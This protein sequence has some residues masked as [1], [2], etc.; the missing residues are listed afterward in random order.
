MLRVMLDTRVPLW[1]GRGYSSEP[2]WDSPGKLC[3]YDHWC[4]GWRTW[5]SVSAFQRS[6][7]ATLQN[8][9]QPSCFSASYVWESSLKNT[10]RL[11]LFPELQI[12]SLETNWALGEKW[13]ER[14]H[15]LLC[16]LKQIF[17]PKLQKQHFI[18]CNALMPM[19]YPQNIYIR[20]HGSDIY[21]GMPRFKMVAPSG[22]R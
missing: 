1:M 12:V 14:F 16:R 3:L 22:C 19:S 15:F 11:P 18:C 8:C 21:L 17:Q 4:S 20:P 2:V 6:L 7:F 10:G 5:G 13:E 9:S